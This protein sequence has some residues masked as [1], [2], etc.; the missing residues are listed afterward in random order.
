MCARVSKRNRVSATYERQKLER[1]RERL[2]YT[3]QSLQT[4]IMGVRRLPFVHSS[5]VSSPSILHL[6]RRSRFGRVPYSVPSAPSRPRVACF[7][8]PG[9]AGKKTLHHRPIIFSKAAQSLASERKTDMSMSL[10]T[11]AD[12]VSF[13][14]RIL[15][16]NSCPSSVRAPAAEDGTMQHTVGGGTA[17]SLPRPPLNTKC[18]SPREENATR[19]ATKPCTE[20]STTTPRSS[21]VARRC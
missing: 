4:C 17:T 6:G 13:D 19:T 16:N 7:S 8:L 15:G 2:S 21:A 3:A 10:Y 9:Q 18:L 20:S 11:P 12:S 5:L 14:P 1:E